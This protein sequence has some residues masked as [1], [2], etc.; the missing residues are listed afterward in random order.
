MSQKKPTFAKSP[1]HNP[2]DDLSMDFSSLK[3]NNNSEADDFAKTMWE[4]VR[5]HLEQGNF[6]EVAKMLLHILAMYPDHVPTLNALASVQVNLARYDLSVP[7]YRQL[8]RLNPTQ[9]DLYSNMGYALVELDEYDEG[10]LCLKR[11]I[12]ETD[13]AF[14]HYALGNAY[15]R[16]GK[17]ELSAKHL[18]IAH[19]KEPNNILFLER[20]LA[21]GSKI[22]SEDDPLVR[23]LLDMSLN[24]DMIARENQSRVYSSLCTAYNSLG[25]YEK[26]FDYAIKAAKAKQF[27]LRVVRH[28]PPPTTKSVKNFFTKELLEELAPKGHKS[29][30]MVF[31]LGM[32][33]S[34]TTLLEQILDAHPECCG[35]GEE[36]SLIHG[37]FDYAYIDP[38][39]G[40]TAPFPFRSN[41]DRGEY[42]HPISL[43]EKHCEYLDKKGITAKR[44][45][46]KAIG[47]VLL[48]GYFHLIFPNA[49][50]IHIKRN[51]MDSCVST[52]QMN[53]RGFAQQYSYNLK[54][55]AQQ[56]RDIENLVDYW[57]EVMPEGKILSIN[58]EDIVDDL[59]GSA[60]K[61][62][63][64]IGLEWDK[65]CLN[66]YKNK[67]V[68]RTASLEQVRKP[69]YK[70]SIGKWKRYGR[71]TLPLIKALGDKA[72][73]EAVEYM[74]EIKGR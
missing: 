45:I 58:Y 49:K 28:A 69:I 4:K 43:G 33:R 29:D 8:V 65:N 23:R 17:E 37:A 71:K 20:S 13:A 32:P 16:L 63:N 25:M 40:T 46:N 18:K 68:V 51:A 5:P 10:L 60:R 56:Y 61:A 72:P 3:I 55:L 1:I 19:D 31:I 54:E 73:A 15:S 41:I 42:V 11:A 21:S 57:K 66:F 38:P 6:S 59:E 47:N 24:I 53:F 9:K 30:Q 34:G 70:N 74:K 26:A 44:V 27:E 22:K 7:L 62:I 50:F 14:A 64:H 52:F 39:E 12:K 35:M 36:D 2:L 67:G 48:A